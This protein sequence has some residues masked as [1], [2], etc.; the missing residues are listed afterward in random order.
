MVVL[1]LSK[2]L[3]GQSWGRVHDA[4]LTE[5]RQNFKVVIFA[6]CT[7]YCRSRPVNTS[8]FND[9]AITNTM[10]GNEI[11]NDHR[12]KPTS[13]ATKSSTVSLSI[14]PAAIAIEQ[15]TRVIQQQQQDKRLGGVENTVNRSGDVSER[16]RHDHE[17]LA[18]EKARKFVVI[19]NVNVLF[20]QSKISWK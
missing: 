10:K 19:W 11:E 7:S 16:Q 12:V 13:V 8:R 9:V 15:S 3:L 20:W 18:H 2:N 17:R 4:S 6:S 5:G 14:N 1:R